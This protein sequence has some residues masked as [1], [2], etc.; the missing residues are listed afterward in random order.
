[1]AK[2]FLDLTWY[3]DLKAESDLR[4]MAVTFTVETIP[5]AKIDLKESQVNGARLKDA[6]RHHKVE[7]Y[8][9]G[10]RNGDTFPRPVVY[11]SPTGY[12]ILS[13]NQRC[14]S[15][16]K[17]IAEGDLP[18]AT[19]L[20][21]YVVHTT[22]KLLLEIIARAAN[23][24]HGEGDTKEERIQ[25]AIYCVKKLG[26]AVKDAAK[27]FQVSV[28]SIRDHIAADDVRNL[29]AKAGVESH[30]LPI[31]HLIQIAKLEF[32]ESLQVKVG[33]LLAQHTVLF[34]RVK[35]LVAVLLKQGSA[36]LRIQVMRDFEKELSASVH[37]TNNGKPAE[38]RAAAIKVPLRPRRDRL[39]SRLTKL[40]NFLESDN[41]GQAF[42]SLEELQVA[43]ESDRE[44]VVSALKKL[45]YRIG[46]LLK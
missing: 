4:R 39:F 3:A 15:V 9:Q 24:S 28:T 17:L 35:Q 8:M 46:V 32:D 14:E 40:V 2:S 19:L 12:V 30:H 33:F 42:T 29:L 44:T 26:M 34:E 36:S 20:E 38:S 25:Q 7:D 43:T 21:C 27:S 10:M 16:R 13:G 5:F 22:D 45:R 23:V 31:G 37:S 1:M 41:D 6:I 11:L 18:K